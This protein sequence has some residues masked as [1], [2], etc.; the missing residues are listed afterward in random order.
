MADVADDDAEGDDG[1]GDEDEE[2]VG[3]TSKIDRE[4]EELPPIHREFAW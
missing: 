1:I 2:E 4:K 3:D